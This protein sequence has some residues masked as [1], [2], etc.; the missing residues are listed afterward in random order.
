MTNLKIPVNPRLPKNFASTQ[1][2]DRPER[3]I[4]Q[5][6][7]RP[8]VTGSDD[9]WSVHCLDGGA[10][11]RPTWRGSF[12]SCDD[13]VSRA[14]EIHRF[15]WSNPSGNALPLPF[16]YEQSFN[17]IEGISSPLRCD[18]IGSSRLL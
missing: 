9:N 2:V 1:N 12:E 7:C 11:D 5:W 10:W 16:P 6:W 18:L 8:F 13:A 15:Y 3:Q 4:R 14:M 17:P